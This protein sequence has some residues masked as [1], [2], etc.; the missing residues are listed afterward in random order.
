M[1]SEVESPF[2]TDEPPI[3]LI[4]RGTL[5]LIRRLGLHAGEVQLQAPFP[6]CARLIKHRSRG[7]HLGVR[8][9]SLELKICCIKNR[10]RFT[11]PELL[12]GINQSARELASYPEAQIGLGPRTYNRHQS[13][14]LNLRCKVHSLNQYRPVGRK[15]C[16][17][18]SGIA[19]T[20]EVHV[21]EH[22]N[23]IGGASNPSLADS[24]PVLRYDLVVPA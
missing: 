21:G 12:T 2:C 20:A 4:L 13:P 9:F 23:R 16:A 15:I 1:V 17:L 24:R 19:T 10:E 5:P 18:R 14:R 22:K 8:L 7:P 11:S 3:G 6:I